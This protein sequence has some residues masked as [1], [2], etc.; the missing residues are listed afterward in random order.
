MRYATIASLVTVVLFATASLGAQAAPPSAA[1]IAA[2]EEAFQI[3]G[4]TYE[5]QAAIRTVIDGRIAQMKDDIMRSGNEDREAAFIADLPAIARASEEAAN[6]RIKAAAHQFATDHADYFTLD[7]LQQIVAFSKTPAGQ[8][9]ISAQ[10]FVFDNKH[11]YTEGLRGMAF[12]AYDSVVMDWQRKH[13][14]H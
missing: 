2:A 8:K 10:P 9:M 1:K 12:E 11:N 4:L 13:A 7:E 5:Y 6:A 3:L 14:R